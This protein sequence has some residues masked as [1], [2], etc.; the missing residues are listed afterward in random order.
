MWDLIQAMSTGHGGMITSVHSTGAEDLIGRVEYMV[1]LADV[2]VN[3]DQ[4]GVAN[5]ISNNFHVAIHLLQ[6]MQTKRRYVN[7]IAVFTG[8]L[9]QDKTSDRPNMQTIFKGGPEHGYHLKLVTDQCP[10]EEVFRHAGLTFDTVLR[11]D[12]EEQEYMKTLGIKTP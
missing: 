7:E 2:P 4:R 1:S 8:R 9:P 3:F 5:L 12:Q 11:A 6:N 10:L